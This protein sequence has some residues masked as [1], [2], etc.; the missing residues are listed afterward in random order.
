MSRIVKICQVLWTSVDSV[1]SGP[2]LAAN[3]SSELGAGLMP[4]DM[5][6]CHGRQT[7]A[8]ALPVHPENTKK[9]PS[10]PCAPCG[11]C[12]RTQWH[13]MTWRSMMQFYAIVT[14]PTGSYKHPTSILQSPYPHRPCHRHF[15]FDSSDF[16]QAFSLL[17]LHAAQSITIG[18]S[19]SIACDLPLKI[20]QTLND[21]LTLETEV[22]GTSEH[23]R[24]YDVLWLLLLI[25]IFDASKRSALNTPNAHP[26]WWDVISS[27]G[28]LQVWSMT[29]LMSS[30]RRSLSSGTVQLPCTA[31][32]EHLVPET[33][34]HAHL[35]HL[36]EGLSHQPSSALG[37]G[38]KMPPAK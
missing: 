7:L 18:E 17:Y 13:A 12:E 34:G 36:A 27:F 4:P 10:E 3:M 38:S 2:G 16:S 8:C 21:L 19:S 33:R 14:N 30:S 1:G 26:E 22:T 32:H 29:S 35:N 5:A 9:T 6:W 23:I 20:R 28:M 25:R 37:R 15:D 24:T 31:P 11:H